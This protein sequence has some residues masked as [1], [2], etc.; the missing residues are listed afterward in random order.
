MIKYFKK[1]NLKKLT[2]N[3]LSILILV[4]WALASRGLGIIR[5]SLTGRLLTINAEMFGAASSLNETIV[6]IFVLGTVGVAALPQIIKLE[7]GKNI[8]NSSSISAEK[9][10]IYISWIILILSGFITFLCFF[11]II[12]SKEFLQFFNPDLFKKTVSLNLAREY[13][14]LNQIFLIAPV[15]FTVKTVLGVFL[16]AK[17]SFKVYSIDGVISNLGSILGLSI[18][19][20]VFGL[21]GAAIGLIIGFLA[22]LILFYWDARKLGFNFTLGKDLITNFPEL[23]GLLIRSFF[24]FLPRLLLFSSARMAEL[25]VSANSKGDGEISILRMA[26]NIQ[27]V[28][29]GLMVAVGA[30]L[31]PDLASNLVK[32][33]RDK[34]FW[35]KII[36][37]CKNTVYMSIGASLLTIFGSP[38]ILY[39]IKILAFVKKDSFLGSESNFWQIIF[40]ISFGSIA[41]IFQSLQE[42]FNRYYIS[43][44]NNKHPIFATTVANIFGILFTYL[45]LTK[46]FNLRADTAAMLG[47]V[48]NTIIGTLMMGF[49]IF[50]D[51]KNDQKNSLDLRIDK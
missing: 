30:V 9:T 4:F 20:W 44:E 19:Y 6:T 47:F 16:N 40:L 8:E 10:N 3:K 14:L 26:L 37:Y 2:G 49:W 5:E 28:F 13:I 51:Y 48:I 35:A 36:K 18:L 45:F 41:I 50:K 15:I 43:Q 34:M 29:Y 33:G 46:Y 24:L 42:I 25:L 38:V 27:G 32:T 22:S 1:L 39:L 12:F 7:G 31:L 17:K 11:G 23:K 21:V